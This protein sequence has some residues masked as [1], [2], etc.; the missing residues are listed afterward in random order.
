MLF[1]NLANKVAEQVTRFL[2]NR[3]MEAKKIIK[4]S[5]PLASS[6]IGSSIVGSSETFHN[7][8][9]TAAEYRELGCSIINKK[10]P[11]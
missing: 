4:S 11:L 3:Q 5:N 8:W 9:V 7:Y 10:C 1:S 2:S 6:W